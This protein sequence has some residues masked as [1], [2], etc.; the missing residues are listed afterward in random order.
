MTSTSDN[1]WSTW[2]PENLLDDFDTPQS[3]VQPTP[4]DISSDAR[5]QLELARL[6][7]KA[8]EKGF[9]QGQAKGLE[10]GK[11]KGYEEGFR[12]G[13]EKGIEQGKRE[14]SQLQQQQADRFEPLLD[15]FQTSLESLDRV[16]SARLVQLALTAARAII[17]E[18]INCNNMHT[19]LCDS[20]QGML[21]EEA[22]FKGK[23]RLWVSGEDY[24]H[25][26]QSTGELLRARGW[27]LC[28]DSKLLPGGCRVVGSEGEL[29]A[30]IET[31]WQELC[32]L[33]REDFPL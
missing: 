32:S 29:D 33:S 30:S 31:R 17:G 6:Q 25:V 20:I 13:K 22:L 14:L 9:A 5:L 21:Q 12:S 10:E 7:Q 19:I 15:S 18:N 3:E 28:S 1:G 16:I 2:L 4:P 27:E 26:E 8:E 11:K 24:P 23:A